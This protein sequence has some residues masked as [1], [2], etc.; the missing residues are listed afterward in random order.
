MNW[1]LLL[2]SL[3]ICIAPTVAEIQN[4]VSFK[5]GNFVIHFDP[6]NLPTITVTQT[7][8]EQPVWSSPKSSNKFVTAAKVNDTVSQIGGNFIFPD[9]PPEAICSEAVITKFGSD[10][11]VVILEGILCGKV[12]FVVVFQGVEVDE[13][14]LF[15][16]ATLTE[17]DYYNQIR[18]SYAC[19]KDEQ[20]Y[21]FGVQYSVFNMKGR[22]LP[23]FLSEQGVGRGLEPFTNILDTLSPGAGTYLCVSITLDKL[24]VAN[25]SA[26]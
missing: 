18:L 26:A 7:G 1:K 3:S 4:P 19:E 11:H 24:L 20:F 25:L 21:G 23:V 15:F 13:H 10:D 12:G 9:A 8:E 22:R 14:V 6:S 2:L 16:S 17:N 5:T